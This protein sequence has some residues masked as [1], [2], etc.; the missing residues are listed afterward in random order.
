[1][2]HADDQL[3]RAVGGRFLDDRIEERDQRLGAFEGEA[4][5][6]DELRVEEALEELGRTDLLEHP[7]P[8]GRRLG[9]LVVALLHASH[10]PL[11]PAGVLDVGELDADAA[12]VGRA[13]A[14]EDLTQRLDRPAGQ[15]PGEE[16][17]LVVV[18]SE[19]VVGR[20]QFGEVLDAR[21]ERVGLGDAVAT[22][23]VGVDQAEHPRVALGDLR[24]RE[25]FRRRRFGL[26][27]LRGRG[28]GRRAGPV[29]QV[30]PAL[31]D[32]VRIEFPALAELG[33]DA[34]VDAE[35]AQRGSVAAACVTGA[36]RGGGRL[37]VALGVAGVGLLVAHHRCHSLPH[38]RVP[39]LV[40]A[41]LAAS[42]G[43]AP[44]AEI[45]DFEQRLKG[46][47]GAAPANLAPAQAHAKRPLAA[48]AG[49][50][51][52]TLRASDSS[53]A[54]TSAVVAA[55]SSGAFAMRRRMHVARG[56]GRSGA[57]SRG[58][59]GASWRCW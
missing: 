46:I 7:E 35:S 40:G 17:V 42:A 47:R 32:R 12:A 43:P 13:Q 51:P 31:V 49:P 20:I 25:A 37:V 11:A 38:R 36:C 53:A 4:L 33:D 8:L 9:R 2:R 27:G 39:S 28:L 19:P 45:D 59:G 3:P 44:Y 41:R 56:S 10:Q 5:L 23:P 22:R 1:M 14:V 34:R 52:Q 29:E 15:V 6:P 30:R 57:N 18:G 24:A 50:R 54:V 48:G 58:S 16:G 55:R 26:R 21:T